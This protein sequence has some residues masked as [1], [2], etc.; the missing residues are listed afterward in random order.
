MRAA[1]ELDY[2]IKCLYSTGQDALANKLIVL[3][4]EIEDGRK[5]MS[6]SYSEYINQ[7]I[8]NSEQGTINMMNALF[9]G[10]EISKN[11]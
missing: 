3:S 8:K 11:E 10:M 7:S 4:T 5:E 1:Q 2:L 9:A 6:N